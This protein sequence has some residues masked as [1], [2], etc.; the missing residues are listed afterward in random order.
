MCAGCSGGGSA[1]RQ[2]RL[3][4]LLALPSERCPGQLTPERDFGDGS[5]VVAPEAIGNTLLDYTKTKAAED[6]DIP[7]FL[8][9]CELQDR[10]SRS[11]GERGTVCKQVGG[12]AAAPM[13]W[14]HGDALHVKRGSVTN[15][16]GSADNRSGVIHGDDSR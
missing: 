7:G 6:L 2:I 9:R 14:C 13:R 8:D 5:F 11:G 16:L 4:D 15:A 1:E 10:A 12:Y 3:R